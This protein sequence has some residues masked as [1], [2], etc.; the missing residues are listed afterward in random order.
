VYL[1]LEVNKFWP[2]K[3]WPWQSALESRHIQSCFSCRMPSN[4]I[5]STK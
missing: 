4:D 3:R 5:F 1:A 2:V